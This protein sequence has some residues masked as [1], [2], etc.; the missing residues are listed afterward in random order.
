MTAT[1]PERVEEIADAIDRTYEDER[2]IFSRKFRKQMTK[3][4]LTTA[5]TE[6]DQQA[7]EVGYAKGVE[8]ERERVIKY[9]GDHCEKYGSDALLH[10]IQKLTSNPP[11]QV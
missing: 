7:R 10:L 8:D 5:L 9:L 3:N 4:T 6:T 2:D 11:S 1:I